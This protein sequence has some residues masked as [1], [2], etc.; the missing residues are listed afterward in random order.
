MLWLYL[1]TGPWRRSLEE[2][3]LQTVEVKKVQILERGGIYQ[4][5]VVLVYSCF[6]LGKQGNCVI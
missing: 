1:T 6:G 3:V 2:I 5:E 4:K